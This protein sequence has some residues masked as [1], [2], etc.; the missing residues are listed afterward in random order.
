MENA[1]KAL[2]IA[3]AVLMAILLIALGMMVFNNSKEMIAQTGEQ[4][5]EQTKQ[6]FNS[7]F[8]AYEGEDV[9]GSKVKALISQVVATNGAS[10]AADVLTERKVEVYTFRGSGTDTPA[11][12]TASGTSLNSTDDSALSNL[13]IKVKSSRHYRVHFDYRSNGL[14]QNIKIQDVTKETP[15]KDS[16]IDS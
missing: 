14:I 12:M 15:F 1:T 11:A 4:I 2:L 5:D 16:L 13:R 6:M 8:E 9:L 10:K 7:K 3:G